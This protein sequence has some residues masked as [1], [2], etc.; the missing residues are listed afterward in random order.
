MGE[1]RTGRAGSLEEVLLAIAGELEAA[2]S[3][4]TAGGR[5]WSIG[6]IVFAATGPEGAE[7][8]LSRPVAAAAL[9]TPDAAPSPRGPDWVAFRP[10]LL[11]RHALDRAEAWLTS[12]WRRADGES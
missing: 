9:R 3:R 8:R 11:D 1:D 7:F 4:P 5:E 2:E 10:P 12:A 6:G